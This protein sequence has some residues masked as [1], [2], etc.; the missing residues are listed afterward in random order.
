M[1][2]K[3]I[4]MAMRRVDRENMVMAWREPAKEKKRPW[5][6]VC[7]LKCHP[8]WQ[9]PRDCHSTTARALTLPVLL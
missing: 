7:Q 3:A 4:N 5:A 8:N 6:E 9:M 1:P 2:A